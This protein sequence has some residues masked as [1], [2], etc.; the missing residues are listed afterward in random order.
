MTGRPRPS[1]GEKEEKKKKKGGRPTG[2]TGPKTK[3]GKGF[4]P[5]GKKKMGWPAAELA[6]KR[7]K[8]KKKN[9]SFAQKIR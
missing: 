5:A 6:S 2:R 3:R 4:G 7:R 8:I 9:I 1:V